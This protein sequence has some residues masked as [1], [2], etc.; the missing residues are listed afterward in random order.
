[1]GI[2]AAFI[3]MTTICI[4]GFLIVSLFSI[5]NVPMV[6]NL[7][8][9]FKEGYIMQIYIYDNLPKFLFLTFP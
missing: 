9:T 8:I 3:L 4:P 7:I 2:E 6:Y 1:M 5:G